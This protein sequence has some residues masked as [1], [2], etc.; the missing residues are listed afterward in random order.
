VDEYRLATDLVVAAVNDRQRTIADSNHTR[1]IAGRWFFGDRILLVDSEVTGSQ[2]AD[3]LSRIEE[4]TAQVVLDLRPQLP[5]GSIDR[6]A[7][8]ETILA[9]AAESFG[10]PLTC[11]ADEPF[12]TLYSGPGSRQQVVVHSGCIPVEFWLIGSFDSARGDCE[13]VWAFRPD[14][15]GDWLG[16]SK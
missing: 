15:Y 8:T 1:L 14:R 9:I 13:L 12:S 10:Y 7:D 5:A 16:A 6:D 2:S 3:G 11:H 4:V